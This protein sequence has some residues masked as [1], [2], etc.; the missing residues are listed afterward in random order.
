MISQEEKNKHS[1]EPTQRYVDGDRSSPVFAE[2]SSALQVASALGKNKT[3]RAYA[4]G[5]AI[6]TIVY[7]IVSIIDIIWKWIK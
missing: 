2:I 1:N 5:I 3:V 6:T 7:N 4:E